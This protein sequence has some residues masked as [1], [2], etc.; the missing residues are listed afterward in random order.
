MPEQAAQLFGL[1][2][3]QLFDACVGLLRRAAQRLGRPARGLPFLLPSQAPCIDQAQQQIQRSGQGG[4]GEAKVGWLLDGQGQAHQPRFGIGGVQPGHQFER[5]G[6]CAEQDV[7]AVVELAAV[8]GNG[9]GTSAQRLPGFV[10]GDGYAGFCQ[11]QR[12]RA[13]CPAAANHGDTRL[14]ASSQVLLAS[15]N[16]RSGVSDTRACSTGKSA[17]RISSSRVR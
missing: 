5:L 6:V 7:L 13:A 1:A 10:Q 15:Q 14:H 9:A 8:E 4:A 17:W 2:R 16:L 3:Q 12:C 11:G